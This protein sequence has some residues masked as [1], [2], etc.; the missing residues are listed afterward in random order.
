MALSIDQ[1]TAA[2]YPAVL[3]TARKPTNQWAENA[4]LRE[5]ERLGSIVKRNLGPTIE[6]TLDYR[7]NPDAGFLGYD[8]EPT[9]TTKTEVITAASYTPVPL[10]VPYVWTK[11]E[12]VQNPT[13]NQ[14]IALVKA[15]TTNALDSHDE[16]IEE[17]IF[18][19]STQGFLGLA[20]IIPTSGQGSVGG[21]DASLETWW[22]NPTDEYQADGSD[23]EAVFTEVWNQVAKGS[24][25]PLAPK[26][27]VSGSEPHALY[28]SQ[29]TPN[30]RFQSTA[31]G[32]SGFKVLAFKTARYVFSQ[33]G[34]TKVYFHN[35]K[36]L[37]IVVSKQYFRD[38]GPTINLQNGEGFKRS[39]FSA[40]Q[41]VTDNKS[42]LAV[43]DEEAA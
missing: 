4:F 40:L 41:T 36:S 29:L 38:M 30:V 21:I 39:I 26:S 17:A 10:S 8:L 11:M 19:T 27:M 2:S 5:L 16:L 25:S 22:R 6:A 13:E 7:R 9:A 37:Q 1:I 18:A 34:G 14:K 24:G 12:E 28:E 35:P 23:I 43:V 32:D 15:K 3:N 31:E 42:R 20:T 33:F